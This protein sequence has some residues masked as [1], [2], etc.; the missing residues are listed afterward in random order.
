[1]TN[2]RDK[3]RNPLLPLQGYALLFTTARETLFCG[4]LLCAAVYV[5]GALIGPFPPEVFVA[6]CL[7]FYGN[8]L[9]V[10]CPEASMACHRPHKRILGCIKCRL[11]IFLASLTVLLNRM[12]VPNR[13]RFLQFDA[14]L[15]GHT[16]VWSHVLWKRFVASFTRRRC[17]I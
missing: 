5:A 6:N 1:M 13:G 12:W 9:I 17:S 8:N 7:Y 16:S 15:L 10:P 11:H 14:A 2:S 4:A 3:D